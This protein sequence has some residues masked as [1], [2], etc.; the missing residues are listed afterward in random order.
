MNVALFFC[1]SAETVANGKLDLR[2]IYNELYA[3]SFP[4][5]QDHLMLAGIVEWDHEDH[6]KQPFKIDLLD[7]DGTEIF[8]IDG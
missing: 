3:P 5:R 8:T 4:A 6:G 2:G 7:P 1:E